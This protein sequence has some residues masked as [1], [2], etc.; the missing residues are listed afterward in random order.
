MSSS[1][2]RAIKKPSQIGQCLNKV[3]ENHHHA[4]LLLTRLHGRDNEKLFLRRLK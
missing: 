1:I 4:P 2:S 3:L